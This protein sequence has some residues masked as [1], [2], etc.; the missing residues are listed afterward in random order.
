MPGHLH[1]RSEDSSEELW[2]T[3]TIGGGYFVR[4]TYYIVGSQI[5]PLSD[6]NIPICGV[7]IAL[8]FIFLRLPTPQGTIRE[9]LARMDWM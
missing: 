3:T 8:V 5:Q 7:A 1:W 9:K 4:L 2:R 6:L